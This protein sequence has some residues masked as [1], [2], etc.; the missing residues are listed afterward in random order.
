MSPL[1][2]ADITTGLGDLDD[3]NI[4]GGSVDHSF[5]L[6]RPC[7]EI[8]LRYFKLQIYP[9]TLAQFYLAMENR[10]WNQTAVEEGTPDYLL[11]WPHEYYGGAAY[12]GQEWTRCPASMVS[13]SRFAAQYLRIDSD[14]RLYA[15]SSKLILPMLMRGRSQN[16]YFRIHNISTL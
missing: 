3:F 11:K 6:H 14:L 8:V 9:Y 16:S 1:T 2:D 4:G 5:P 7:E 13:L 10:F 15:R 12:Q